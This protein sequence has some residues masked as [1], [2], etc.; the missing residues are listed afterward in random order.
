MTH[1]E[2]M[3]KAGLAVPCCATHITFGGRCLNCG[4]DPTPAPSFTGSLEEE[5]TNQD[6]L[7]AEE[8]R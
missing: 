7:D 3:K 4:Y 2:H 1:F 6:M 5:L 8:A